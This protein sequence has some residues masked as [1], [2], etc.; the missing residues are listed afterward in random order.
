LCCATGVSIQVA[1]NQLL[2][3]IKPDRLLIKP[4][5]LCHPREVLK[6]L[7]AEH[8]QTVLALQKT[9][10]LVDARNLLDHYIMPPN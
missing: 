3:R 5:G 6:V 7:L 8:Y 1:L 9:I 10:T 4:T 2:K